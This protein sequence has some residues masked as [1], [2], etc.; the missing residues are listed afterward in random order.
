[1]KKQGRRMPNWF[2]IPFV[3]PPKITTNS[4]INTFLHHTFKGLGFG[5]EAG[6]WKERTIK[7]EKKGSW[8]LHKKSRNP[9]QKTKPLFFP[10]NQRTW[11][12]LFHYSCWFQNIQRQQLKAPSP[13]SRFKVSL[14][15]FTCFSFWTSLACKYHSINVVYIIA[16]IGKLWIGISWLGLD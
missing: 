14:S 3:F 12:F 5:G 2:K 1:M 6:F 16:W 13:H 7:R 4:P 15:D 10:L 9:K 11:H 8:N